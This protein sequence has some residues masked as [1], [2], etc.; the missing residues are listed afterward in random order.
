MSTLNKKELTKKERRAIEHKIYYAKP[1]VTERR[2]ITSKAYNA[3]PEIKVKHSIREKAYN[4]RPEIKERNAIRAKAYNARPEIKARIAI[5]S[6]AY[7]ERPEI[8]ERDRERNKARDRASYARKKAGYA[9]ETESQRRARLDACNEK[10]RKLKAT[11][12]GRE[13]ARQYE[14][15][16]PR[17]KPGK[18]RDEYLKADKRYRAIPAVRANRAIKDKEYL[19][20]LSEEKKESRHKSAVKWRKNHVGTLS[21][22][23]IKGLLYVHHEF[24]TAE[25][26]TQELIILK[27][28]QLMQ[29]REIYNENN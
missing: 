16:R 1:G 13:R 21:D 14:R 9:K 19:A 29:Y 10:V 23:Y 12:E 22:G 4:A 17:R 5:R 8:K 27:R 15:N 6:K 20:N 26:I 25:D 28:H 7:R 11:P 24:L 18:V 3:R 2:A